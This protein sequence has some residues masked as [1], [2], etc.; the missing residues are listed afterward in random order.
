MDADLSM[1]LPELLLMTSGPTDSGSGSPY[2]FN[3]KQE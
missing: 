1:I 3:E 2:G